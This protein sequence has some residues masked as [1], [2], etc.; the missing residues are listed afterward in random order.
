MKI[1]F[2]DLYF[3]ELG[4]SV[5]VLLIFNIKLLYLK[6]VLKDKDYDIDANE[7]II[8][9][10]DTLAPW[11]GKYKIS[12]EISL[13]PRTPQG[14]LILV[15]GCFIP[16]INTVFSFFEICAIFNQEISI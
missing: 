6:Y 9:K 11:S 5:V 8:T 7:K 15:I 1:N 13:N 2:I 14:R 4:F 12:Y 16:I 10:T 3:L